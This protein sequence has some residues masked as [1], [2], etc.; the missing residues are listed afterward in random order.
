M[1]DQCDHETVDTRF[2]PHCGTPMAATPLDE[3]RRHIRIQCD[4]RVL[5]LHKAEAMPVE[6]NWRDRWIENARRGI[7]K[8]NN[9]K[10]VLEDLIEKANG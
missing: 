10:D 3:L 5:D 7:T 1:K 4:R 9:W 6:N 8:W 2:C